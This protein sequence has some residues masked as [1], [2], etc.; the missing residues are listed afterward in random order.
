MNTAAGNVE[1]LTG[2]CLCGAATQLSWVRLD[3]GLTR[4]PQAR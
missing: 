4:F 2:G 1:I 3:D